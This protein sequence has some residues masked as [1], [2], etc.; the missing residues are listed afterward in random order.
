MHGRDDG[1]RADGEGVD[2]RDGPDD[3]RG[4]PDD[5]DG[6]FEF[7]TDPEPVPEGSSE[8]DRDAGEEDDRR[9]V[10]DLP[11]EERDDSTPGAPPGV[12]EREPGAGDAVTGPAPG[13]NAVRNWTILS[14]L[15][16]LAAFV[17]A[18]VTHATRTDPVPVAAAAA[19]GV[20]FLAL[21]VG[22]RRGDPAL[23]EVLSAGWAEHRRHTWLATGLFGAGVVL[24][25]ALLLA[26]VDLFDLFAELV[27][28]ELFPELEDEGFEPTATFF[29]VNNTRA[30]LLTIVGALSVG[31]LTAFVLVFNGLVVG[32]LA[33][34]IG[35]LV[36]VEYL[37]VGLAPHGVFEL[38]A[39]FVAAGVGFRFVHRFVQRVLGRRDAFLTRTY[40]KRTVA[41]VVFA[42]L[43]LV[44][45]AFVEAYVTV[46][47][48]EALFPGEAG[49][50]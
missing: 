31:L 30:F 1:G 14:L 22:G 32:N 50:A 26:G 19:L 34:A 7:V 38:P 27:G 29:V 35:G 24:G 37:A 15:L 23:H 43:L 48:L 20:G 49:P 4:S 33:T 41:L 2:D 25:V 21:G 13:P 12:P 3:D 36:G 16:A 42:W 6:G 45:A 46:E 47:L 28:E 39:L 8:T 11:P 40:L 10:V 18:G 5:S 44:L 17:T 9:I